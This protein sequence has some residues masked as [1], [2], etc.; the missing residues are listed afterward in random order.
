MSGESSERVPMIRSR[1][2]V[3]SD[4]E[5]AFEYIFQTRDHVKGPFCALL[6]SPDIATRVGKLGT[7]IRFE[8]E[9]AGWVRELA[10][11]TTAREHRC[12]YEWAYHEPIARNEGVSETAVR[13]VRNR[14]P[15]KDLSEE[16]ALVV[17]YAR[18]LIESNEI[19]DSTFS[20]AQR[21]F[22]EQELVELTTTIG[23]YGMLA[24]VIHAFGILPESGQI[25]WTA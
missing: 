21:H 5:E 24:S 11:L 15:V 8:S 25:D 10:V 12:A 4:A 14:D 18:E 13:I 22:S 1:S 6:H 20:R 16:A 9:L 17:R 23:Y 7:Y 19:S 2:D 3:D